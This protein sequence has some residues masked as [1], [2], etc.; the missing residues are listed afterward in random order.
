M[1]QLVD[2]RGALY[3]QLRHN[4]AITES[5]KRLR[6]ISSLF[7]PFAHDENFPP[8]GGGMTYWRDIMERMGVG[9]VDLSETGMGEIFWVTAS[10]KG[11]G[12]S[13]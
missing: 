11:D 12:G 10:Q 8:Q 9:G 13:S 7:L 4:K 5:H 3:Q 6:K 1:K 2:P